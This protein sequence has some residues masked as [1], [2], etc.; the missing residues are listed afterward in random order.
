MKEQGSMRRRSAGHAIVFLLA[1]IVAASAGA[2]TPTYKEYTPAST[3]DFYFAVCFDKS[4]LRIVVPSD[5]G[6][7]EIIVWRQTISTSG[8]TTPTGAS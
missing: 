7:E 6:R 8:A 3:R 2:Q 5:Q 4:N 1:L